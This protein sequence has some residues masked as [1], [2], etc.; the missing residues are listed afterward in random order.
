MDMRALNMCSYGLYILTSKKGDKINGQ[1][2]NTVFQ[3]AAEP[4]TMA[5]SV[6]KQNLTHDYISESKVFAACILSTE[7]PMT[8][9]GKWGFKSGRDTDKFKGTDYRLGETGA[10][11]ILDHTVAYLEARV[12]NTA[13]AGT[14][15]IFIGEVVDSGIIGDGEPMTYAYYHK[16]KKGKTPE[17]AATYVKEEPDRDKPGPT[18][19]AGK[20]VT[21]LKK[22]TC[23]VCG[24]VYDPA[25]GDP[26]NGVK[27]GTAFEKL[28]D[29]WVCP[30]CGATKDQFTPQG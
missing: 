1:I 5:V 6:N 19:A 25:K 13:D 4:P 10:P 3:V 2:V 28:P 20:E 12:V 21:K 14:H 11:I 9:I 17:R 15:T 18:E 30:V 23:S 24:Y 16:V 26:D 8:L 22:Y 7:A 27:P 29:T